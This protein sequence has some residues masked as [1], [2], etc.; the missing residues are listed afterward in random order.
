MSEDTDRD[1]SPAEYTDESNLGKRQNIDISEMRSNFEDPEMVYGPFMFWFW[2]APLMASS[3]AEMA[4]AMLSQNINPGYAHARHTMV[5]EP[6]LDPDEGW[7]SPEWFDAFDTAL[8]TAEDNEGYL[9]YCDEYW[10]PSMRAAGRVVEDNPGLAGKY[11]RWRTIDVPGG[12]TTALP[13]VSFIVAARIAGELGEGSTPLVTEEDERHVP[14]KIQSDTIRVLNTG[15]SWTAPGG[16]DWRVYAFTEASHEEALAGEEFTGR[17]ETIPSYVDDDLAEAFIDAA[18]EPYADRFADRMGGPIPADFIDNEGTYGKSLAWSE[19]LR[20]RY[21]AEHDRSIEPRMPLMIDQDVEGVCARARIHWFQTVSELYAG[22]FSRITEW[23]ERRGMY[24]TG[25]FW[26]ESFPAQVRWVGDHLAMQRALSMPGQDCLGD[27]AM[28]I[29]DFK[30]AQ[31]VAEFEGSRFMTEFMGSSGATKWDQYNITGEFSGGEWETFV[32]EHIK[33]FSN[34]IFA[35]GA[36]HVI[37]HGIFMTRRLEGN[38]W[39][40]DW[41]DVNPMFSQLHNWADFIRRGSYVHSH[42][43]HVADVL[44]V[45]P[46]ETVWALSGHQVFDETLEP[47]AIEERWSFPGETPSGE[48]INHIDDVYSKAMDR[49]A[50]ERIEYLVADSYYMDGMEVENG[51]LRRDT[52]EFGGVVLPPMDVLPLRTAELLVK[53]ATDGGTVVALGE[54]PTGS[55][56]RGFDDSEME[57]LMDRLSEQPSFTATEDLTSIV[58]TS[59][60][61]RQVEF[62]DTEFDLLQHHRRIDGREF[63]W[64][65]ND[66]DSTQ[67][68]E[69][70]FRGVQGAA[71]RWGPENGEI[72][73]VTTSEAERGSRVSLT[74]D[75]YEAYW[76]VFDQDSP[77]T[78]SV[79]TRGSV[80]EPVTTIDGPWR[81]TYDPD[82]QPPLENPVEPPVEFH[83]DG[84][85]REL[86]DWHEDW[87]IPET[88]SGRLDYETTVDLDAM[89]GDVL[90]DLGTVHWAAEVWIDGERVGDGLWPPHRIAID[91]ALQPGETVVRVRIAN[92]V[93]NNYGA[94]KESG[95]FGPVELLTT[96]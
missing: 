96:S 49:L 5:D 12:T 1:T 94:P 13:E 61:E 47:N 78:A 26:E 35:W 73:P 68:G 2:D 83:A 44:L 67:N 87:G 77:A 84:T 30:E 72:E 45:N 93:N 74:F 7:L 55:T 37:P 16:G 63:F 89:D 65:A 59:G 20:Q 42:G 51:H 21:E 4:E 58:E 33:R 31:S 86:G 18:L 52:Y 66:T 90:L 64:L 8:S 70:L 28:S 6:S 71:E 14:R 50:A 38:P 25:H 92:L 23:H 85:T 34:A 9:G 17:V 32:P 91:D 19:S 60:L 46:K 40:P 36:S 24:T 54:L 76:L 62:V 80:P 41:Y 11:L 10:W 3:P 69:L 27:N 29:H 95:L 56:K 22:N 79:D 81:I 75:P 82:E 43:D 39:T 48:R 53:F 57:A 15:E 88:F